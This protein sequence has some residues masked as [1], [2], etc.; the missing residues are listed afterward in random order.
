[1]SRAAPKRPPTMRRHA[2][3]RPASGEV[4]PLM[5]LTETA[6][7]PAEQTAPAGAPGVP[8]VTGIA[9]L[10]GTSDHKV[11]GRLY[12]G[13]AFLFM[14]GAAIC[15]ELVAIDRVDGVT[16]NTILSN[17]NFFQVFTFQMVASTLLFALPLLL[18]LA[19][20]LVPLQIGSK[21]LAFPRAAAASYWAFLISGSL[22]VAS[23]M[24]N[25]GP[26]GGSAKGVDLWAISMIGV[27]AS[28]LL[29]TLCAVTTVMALRAPGMTLNRTPLFS[30]SV[31][32]SGG[33]WLLSLPILAG[34]LL[35]VYVGH[36]FGGGKFSFG[37]NAEIYQ[38]IRWTFVQPQIY[39]LAAPILG[40][41]GDVVLTATRRRHPLH[42]VAMAGIGAFAVLGFGAYLS[43]FTN[44][45][46]STEPLYVIMAFGAIIPLLVLGGLWADGM[47]RGPLKL[48]SPL[49]FA[50]AAFLMLLVGVVAGAAGSVS[51]FDLKGTVWDDAVTHYVLLAAIIGGLGGLH[52][53]ASKVVGR[54]LKEPIGMLAALALLGGTILVALP[55]LISGI[56]AKG[57]ERRRGIEGLNVIV[58]IG[59]AF[60][61]IGAVLAVL[62]VISGARHADGEFPSDPWEGGLTLEWATASPPPPDNFDVLLPEVV[63]EA[64]LLDARESEEV[65]A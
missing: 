19:L 16:G 2:S 64:P 23:Y 61:I 26:G 42:N 43:T 55:D 21:T 1:M 32:V 15:G 38:R 50:G 11:V 45:K 57:S 63:S 51:T 12:I 54:S 8:P 35:L 30:W 6:P 25:G 7:Q 60:V 52:H 39:A 28:L 14:I 58:V 59:G 65:P 31:L 33:V 46:A 5:A 29:G 44:A 62:N 53:W 36:R 40:I 18:G 37:A 22:V 3:V 20:V 41:V 9:A 10:V 4:P 56:F 48:T 49:V 34:N 13:T 27:V 24:M 47:R 17:N